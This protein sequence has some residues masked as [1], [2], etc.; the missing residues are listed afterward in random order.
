MGSAAAMPCV[1]GSLPPPSPARRGGS[2]PCPLPVSSSSLSSSSTVTCPPRQL[3]VGGLRVFRCTL[4]W[5]D[6]KT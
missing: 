6:S 4:H 5:P 2:L 1:G 3:G